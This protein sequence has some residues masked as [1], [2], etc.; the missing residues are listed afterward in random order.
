MLTAALVALAS[1]PLAAQPTLPRE[2]MGE[3]SGERAHGVVARLAGFGTRHTLSET[4]GDTRG[5]GAAR[6]WIKGELE[7]ANEGGGRLQVA[8]E[9][10]EAPASARLRGGGRLVNVVAVLPGTDPVAAGR[11][12]Y[13]VGHYDSRNANGNDAEGDAPGANDD[14]S[15]VGVVMEIARVLAGRPLESTVVFLATAGEEQGLIGARYHAEQARARGER[16]VGVLN[17]DIVGDPRGSGADEPASPGL[18]RVFSEGVPR[19][20]SAEEHARIRN[21][22]AEMDS[23]S[24]QLARFIDEVGRKERTLVRPMVVFR[25]DRFLRGGDHSAFLEAGFPGVRF[26]EVGEDYSRQHADVVEKDGRP[27]G[28]LAEWVDA[29][30]LGNVARLNAAV[31]VHLANAPSTPA[32]VRIITAQLDHKTTLRWEASPEGDVA[33]YEVVWRLTTDWQWQGVRDVGA[34]TSATLPLNKDNY[35]VGVRAYDK[36]GYRSPVGFAGAASR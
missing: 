15:G 3:I 1:L 19:Q 32:R 22:A 2:V 6:R 20:P 12:Y 25:L 29:E 31:L 8:F 17:N 35:F 18:I 27:Y 5:I 33:G 10:F 34:E 21:L 4:E 28:D 24:R 23:P 26:T 7:R 36:D 30:Y 14:A 9:E 16:I 13:V 11:R